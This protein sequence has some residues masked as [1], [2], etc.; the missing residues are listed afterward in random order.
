MSAQGTAAIAG[1]IGSVAI[2][3]V[4]GT[5][6]TLPDIALSS[7]VLFHVERAA[8]LL[9]SYIFV[10]VVLVRAWA[11]ELPIEMSSQG[12]KYSA[13]R[14]KDLTSE[15]IAAAVEDLDRLRRRVDRLEREA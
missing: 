3:V 11:G 7:A 10:L 15:A 12:V 1:L 9:A 13:E 2:T 5:P 6:P 4:T 8:A 14:V